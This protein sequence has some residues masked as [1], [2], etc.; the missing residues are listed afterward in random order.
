MGVASWFSHLCDAQ[1]DFVSNER[2]VWVDVEGVPL[3]AWSRSTF[4]KIGSKWGEVMDLEECKNDL[5]APNLDVDSDVD[6][7]FETYFGDQEENRDLD[8]AQSV[9]RKENSSD[10][11]NIYDLLEKRNKEKE[12]QGMDT[13]T[14]HPPG[15][16][17]EKVRID[18]NVI[19]TDSVGLKSL[20]IHSNGFNS[21]VME[22]TSDVDVQPTSFGRTNTQELKKGG[23]ILEALDNMIKVGQTMG[24]LMEGC[25]KDVENI[26]GSHGDHSITA[27]EDKGM[28]GNSHFDHIFSDAIG[29]SGGLISRWNGES[30]VMGDFNEVRFE[31]NRLGLV[32]N[33]QGANEFN[34]FITNSGLVKIQLEGFSFTWSHPSASKMSKL[35]RF[36]VTKG[37]L[38]LFPHTSAICLDKNL[39]D[40]HPILLWE[41]FTNYGA[42][43]FRLYHSWFNLD[44]FEQMVTT[45]WHSIVHDDSNGMLGDIKANETR[46]HM[47]KAKIKWAIEG[48]ENQN[49]HAIVNRKRANL[50]IKGIMV[51]EIGLNFT[52]PNRLTLEKITDLEKPVSNDE[53]RKA[54]WDCGE[55]KS[56]GPDGFSFE[57]FRKF[58]STIGPDICAAVDWFFTHGIKNSKLWCSKLILLKLMILFGGIIWMTFITYLGLG[59][60]GVLRLKQGDPLAPYLFILVIES[61]HLSVSR[62]VEAGIFF[63]KIQLL[64]VGVSND[65]L[66]GAA[67]YIGCAVMKTPFK[68]LGV[69]VG[70]NM[71]KI[72]AWDKIIG[73]LKSCLS[74]WKLKTL[75]IGGR[76]TLL[77]SVLGATPIYSMSLY[78]VPKFVLNSMESIR[79]N[80]FNGIQDGDRKILWVKWSKVLSSKKYGGLGVSSFFALNRALLFKWIWRFISHDNSLWFRFILAMHGTCIQNQSPFHFSTWNAIVREVNVLKNKGVDLISYCKIRVGFG[81]N[82]KFWSDIWVGDSPLFSLFPRLYALETV[83]DSTDLV[84]SKVL[85]HVDDR[86]VWDLNGEGVFRVKDAR[87]FLDKTFLPKENVATR[88]VKTI[89]IKINVFVWKLY[90]DRIPTRFNLLRRG[91]Q[92]SSTECPI[93]CNDTEDT[94]HV[95]SVAVWPRILIVSFVGGGIYRGF[96]LGLIRIGWFGLNPLDWELILK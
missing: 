40:H 68:Y 67:N 5:L 80:F 13:S 81:M 83:K 85:S 82:T 36:L 70:G 6:G 46:D 15:F 53:I 61:L 24:F 9:N 20:L 7:V 90:L 30:I 74:K 51:D 23:S 64:G 32:F 63:Q 14:S 94:S 88:W 57:F 52:F 71:S 33:A 58:W 3:H 77:K 48:D 17:P 41:V 47:Q 26:T 62:A 60:N 37:V 10:P 44:G 49:F 34:N 31:R 50:S 19:V 35:D 87:N 25:L 18:A 95:F 79:R 78:K 56:P 65:V 42:T 76:L 22:D 11:F 45:S 21:R 69:M 16:T 84:G 89:P 29:N 59:L 28:W 96:R 43:P 86:W 91:V 55:N 12:Q 66:S 27:M 75:S 73:K 92:V 38:S 93:C 2:I 8:Q 54:V 72:K 1:P 4:Y 39:S